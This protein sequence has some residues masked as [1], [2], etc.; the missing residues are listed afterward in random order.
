MAPGPVSVSLRADDLPARRRFVALALVAG[1][2]ALD[3]A[4][5]A[6]GNPGNMGICGACFL[7]DTGGALGLHAGKGPA[8][9]RPEVAGLVF[10]ALALALAQRR[11]IGRSGSHAVARFV[12]GIWMAVAALVFLGCPFR[13]LQRLGGGDL[14]AWIA[15]PG[16]VAGVGAGLWLERRGYSVGTTSQAPAAVGFLGPLAMAALLALFLAGDLL[17]GPGPSVS[18]PPPHAPWAAALALAALGGAAMSATGFCAV[19]AARQVFQRR[20]LMLVA[21][22]ALVAGYA[23]VSVATDRFRASFAGQPIAHGDLVWNA[24][25]LAL[26]GLAGALAGG[27]PVRQMVMTGEGNGDAFVTVAGLVVGGSIAHNLGLVSAAASEA[28][29]GG[30][31]FAGRVAVWIG[32]GFAIA[33]GVA[34]AHRRRA[35]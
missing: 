7:R 1:V 18:G 30:P 6:L 17:A 22:L 35:G 33:Y 29:P 15:L 19:T 20:K 25:A 21:A 26:L 10:G 8:I 12:L 23:A 3:A 34:V 2:G 24:L 14:N 11:S 32:L 28:G 4:R 13:L 9:F 5:V 16:F 27:C 31:T